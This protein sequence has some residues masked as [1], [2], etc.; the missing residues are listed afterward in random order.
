MGQAL[1]IFTIISMLSE[2]KNQKSP[3]ASV[4]LMA[5]P[6]PVLLS[7]VFQSTFTPKRPP[8]RQATVELGTHAE[9]EPFSRKLVIWPYDEE[10]APSTVEFAALQPSDG[11]GPHEPRSWPTT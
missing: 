1:R 9:L 6:L 11:D 7:E 8:T 2:P 5:V 10:N 4:Y 3:V